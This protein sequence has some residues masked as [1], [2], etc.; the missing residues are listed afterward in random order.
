MWEQYG[1]HVI[2]PVRGCHISEKTSSIHT[3]NQTTGQ[4]ASQTSQMVGIS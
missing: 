2:Q 4:P 1:H 3:N